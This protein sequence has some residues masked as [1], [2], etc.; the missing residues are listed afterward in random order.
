[1]AVRLSCHSCSAELAFE[2]PIGRSQHCPAC[3]AELRC[4]LNCRFHDL[5]AYNE[6]AEPSAERVLE[7]DRANFCDYFSPGG[8]SAA[9]AAKGDAIAGGLSELEKLFRKS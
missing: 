6:C 8:S 1:M 2:D 5:S 3:A 4:C 7:K 9:P